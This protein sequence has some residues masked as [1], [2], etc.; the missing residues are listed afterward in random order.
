MRSITLTMPASPIALAQAVEGLARLNLTQM[1]SV[2]LY[3]SGVRYK[4]E[5]RGREEWLG[6]RDALAR[7]V[8]DC[9]DLAAWRLA[10]LWRD[11][12]E[13]SAEVSPPERGM[14][15][16]YLRTA[17]GVEDP[18]VVLGMRPPRKELYMSGNNELSE[19]AEVAEGETG[20]V[21]RLDFDAFDNLSDVGVGGDDD[22]DADVEASAPRPDPAPA[23]AP[24]QEWAKAPPAV[25]KLSW[26]VKGK[27]AVIRVPV[28]GGGAIRVTASDTSSRAALA[29]AARKVLE[30]AAEVALPPQAVAVA[31]AVD[32]L[33]QMVPADVKR[34]AR[35]LASSAARSLAAVFS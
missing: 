7:G 8:A 22:D 9:E 28:E 29:S 1:P 3:S 33:S 4:R 23:R 18:S 14:M 32:K 31:K 2:P 25:R 19:L 15:H 24:A 11:G 10:E 16:V 35:S 21:G 5:R 26:L 27:T 34:K 30:M 13:A 12:V 6:A 20:A 17:S